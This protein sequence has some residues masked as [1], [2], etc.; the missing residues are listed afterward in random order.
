MSL[1]LLKVAYSQVNLTDREKAAALAVDFTAFF[2][3]QGELLELT[4]LVK[5]VT[6]SGNQFQLDVKSLEAIV[7][8]FIKDKTLFNPILLGQ[9]DGQSI[10]LSGRNRIAALYLLTLIKNQ[11]SLKVPVLKLTFRNSNLLFS[12]VTAANSSRRMSKTEE[13]LTECSGILPNITLQSVISNFDRLSDKQVKLAL[14]V[15]I[16]DRLHTELGNSVDFFG[17]SIALTGSKDSKFLLELIQTCIPK[18]TEFFTG[19]GKEKFLSIAKIEYLVDRYLKPLDL[20][21]LKKLGSGKDSLVKTV[22]S[23]PNDVDLTVINDLPRVLQVV[24]ILLASGEQRIARA[25]TKGFEGSYSLKT[26][27]NEALHLSL[28]SV[29]DDK[30]T[31]NEVSTQQSNGSDIDLSNLLDAIDLTNA[32]F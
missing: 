6:Q 27:L 26:M 5:L 29:T 15:C 25:V 13:C 19:K 1:E 10:I 2:P 21:S 4:E 14:S 11:Q 9:A 30:L 12:A 8:S 23:V 24:Y 7:K 3:Y 22:K 20:K 31:S 17:K 32:E 16:R 18:K 28:A